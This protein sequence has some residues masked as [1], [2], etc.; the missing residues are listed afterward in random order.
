MIAPTVNILM[1]TSLKAGALIYGVSFHLFLAGKGGKED[2]QSQG[3]LIVGRGKLVGFLR[4]GKES[5]LYKK[6]RGLEPVKQKN[7]RGCGL[8]ATGILRLQIGLY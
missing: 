8:Y 2:Q 5:T 4:I 3:L 7:G 1:R 6:G